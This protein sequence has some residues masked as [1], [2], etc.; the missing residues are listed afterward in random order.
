MN[1]KLLARMIAWRSAHLM[2]RAG[3]SV[4]VLAAFLPLWR[5]TRI[6]VRAALGSYGMGTEQTGRV[7]RMLDSRIDRLIQRWDKISR[8]L[9]LSLRN[10]FRRKA[11]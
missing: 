11:G 8:P 1:G 9:R 7:G 6:P 2:N 5:G 3:W 4:S 10:T